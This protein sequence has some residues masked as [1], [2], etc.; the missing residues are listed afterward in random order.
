MVF[1]NEKTYQRYVEEGKEDEFHREFERALDRVKEELGKEYPL[2]IGEKEVKVN[3]K[4]EVRSPFDTSILVG[5][6]QKAGVNEIKDSVEVAKKAFEEWQYVDWHERVE[7][8]Y[9][10]AELMKR[11]KF[12]LAAIITYENGKNRFESVAEVDEAI[13]YFMY[14]A[15][16]LEENKGYVRPMES[17]IYKNEIAYSVMK[18]YGVWAIIS[19]FNFPLA[20]TTT[21]TIS[22]VITGNTAIIKPSSDTP[23]SGFKLVEIMRRAGFPKN[24]VNYV[25]TS[26]ELFGKEIIENLGIAGFAF[27][28]SRE[29]GHRLL[30]D[31]ISK[32]PRPAVLELGGKNATI[33]TKKADLNK[34]VEGTLRGAFGFGGQK[35]SATSRIFVEEPIYDNFVKAFVDKVKSI[36]IGDPRD[37][38]TFLGPLINRQ[39]IEKY[40]KY[41]EEVRKS[42]GKILVGGNVKDDQRGYFVE[43]TVVVEVPYNHWLWYTELFVPIVLIGKVKSLE[44]AI[45]LANNVDYGL[46]AG[47][48]S[49]DKKE[50]EFFFSHIQAGVVYANRI[51]GS[52]TGA[53]PGVQPFGG[54][55]HSGWTGKNAGG[56]Y[57][58]LS[59]L[60][61]QAITE[62]V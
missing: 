9:K 35:C 54:W 39:A 57:Y 36:V 61:E 60:R 43:P 33:I 34:S 51:A 10:A 48:F 29:V 47:I 55:K 11:Q 1:V 13:D 18:P 12:E 14:Y 7:L 22:A 30:K 16:L 21:M 44:E 28:G 23:L 19:P 38:R 31:F 5:K 46:T 59:F 50:I 20:I 53:M 41:I 37:R 25:T 3:D 6:F 8:S 27:T 2:L 4:F 40:R 58:L 15:Y 17:R 24:T 56:P 49:E 45:R 32:N 52:T 42:N 62:Y 26:G